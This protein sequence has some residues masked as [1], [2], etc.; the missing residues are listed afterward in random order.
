MELFTLR[1]IE[2]FVCGRALAF[3]ESEKGEWPGV[4]RTT[5][6]LRG[7]SL[8]N[9]LFFTTDPSMGNLSACSCASSPQV[10]WGGIV[11]S[12]DEESKSKLASQRRRYVPQHDRPVLKEEESRK[13]LGEDIRWVVFRG[14]AVQNDGEA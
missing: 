7:L 12:G 10:R 1:N 11:W 14:N 6:N 8:T 5:A 9:P 4:I 2:I 3:S 13:S